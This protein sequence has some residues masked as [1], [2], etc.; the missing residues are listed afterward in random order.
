MQVSY[1]MS[2]LSRVIIPKYVL[3]FF[4]WR[5]SALSIVGSMWTTTGL[6]APGGL[7]TKDHSRVTLRVRVKV[8][9]D[10]DATAREGGGE[11]GGG[12]GEAGGVAM[13]L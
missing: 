12:G 13:G 7:V 1:V 6:F 10:A 11:G 3:N 9:G 5:L 8:D 2:T 4:L